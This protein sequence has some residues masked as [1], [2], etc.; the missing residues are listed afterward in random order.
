MRW[1]RLWQFAAA[2]VLATFGLQAPARA[3]SGLLIAGANY[4]AV[5]SYAYLGD[6]KPVAGGTLGN[7]F[8]VSPFV[9]VSRYTFTGNA[10]NFTGYQPAASLG[11]GYSG[12][13]GPISY[14]L[15]GAG[16][17]AYTSLSPFRPTGSITG[18][19][20]FLEPEIYLQA[21]TSRHTRLVMNGGYLLG[22][23]SYWFCAYQQTDL[24]QRFSAG[25][26]LDLGGGSNYRNQAMA[27][28]LGYRIT[29]AV[30][31]SVSVGAQRSGAGAW[32]PYVAL[33]LSAPF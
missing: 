32:T 1:S 16:G 30:S 2:G 22:L 33:G 25:P 11:V 7:G 5:G 4:S 19:Q 10:T 26:E 12:G 17:V 9:G 3:A 15:S 27:L 13:F 29:A 20:A 23:R 18:A 14:S 28:R 21:N 6:I 8:F 31:L 24:G